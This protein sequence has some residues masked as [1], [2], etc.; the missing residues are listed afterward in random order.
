[1][2]RLTGSLLCVVNNEDVITLVSVDHHVAVTT[3]LLQYIKKTEE[4]ID[5]ALL[6]FYAKKFGHLA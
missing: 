6:I 3:C 1:M 4:H 5:G 2:L